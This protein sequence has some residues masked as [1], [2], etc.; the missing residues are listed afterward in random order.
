MAFPKLLSLDVR[1]EFWVHSGVVNF[2]V[3]MSGAKW[4]LGFGILWFGIQ[5]SGDAASR[6]LT[7]EAIV[8]LRTIQ[9]SLL[10]QTANR[11]LTLLTNHFLMPNRKIRPTRKFG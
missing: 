8:S 7:A 1:K 9:A 11:S 10:V 2:E 6:Q 4:L 5:E 3:D